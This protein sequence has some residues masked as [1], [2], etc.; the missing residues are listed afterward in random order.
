MKKNPIFRKCLSAM[1][2][3]GAAAMPLSAAVD[4][5]AKVVSE[6]GDTK[7]VE[8]CG[9]GLTEKSA[10]KDATRNAVV[11]VV[12]QIVDAQTIT[13]NEDAI[14]DK[15]V[16]V[17]NG[18]VDAVQPIEGPES[19]GGTVLVRVRATVK[20]GQMKTD[21]VKLS[22]MSMDFNPSAAKAALESRV[23]NV[24]GMGNFLLQIWDTYIKL[25]KIEELKHE[26]SMTDETKMIFKL[27]CSL[28]S[29][30]FRNVLL[31]SLR[32]NFKAM[33]IK[34]VE[35]ADCRNKLCIWIPGSKRE[36]YSLDKFFSGNTN[37]LWA[38]YV[39]KKRPQYN[40]VIECLSEDGEV[41]ASNRT[42]FIYSV[43][44][45]Y[46]GGS[47]DSDIFINPKI[48]GKFFTSRE[49]EDL[50]VQFPTKED[51]EDVKTIKIYVEKVL[52]EE[53]K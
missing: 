12:G 16:S 51:I 45:D 2:L 52:P 3:L 15:I 29:R 40:L 30:D 53:E 48:N 26:I 41:I 50:E 36:E 20:S 9:R 33:K 28:N 43:G 18:F 7:V 10:I 32:K 6:D 22:E 17:S 8:I 23:D 38:K 25:F 47:R 24:A 4:D 21:I 11:F 27:K 46:I 44:Y 19:R 31:K 5:E 39:N 49:L 34:P 13:Q 35:Y 42:D 37:E 14:E 1:L